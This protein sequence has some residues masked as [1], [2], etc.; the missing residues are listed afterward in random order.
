MCLLWGESILGQQK[1]S[2]SMRQK[3][4]N[5]DTVLKE[6]DSWFYDKKKN[7]I[8]KSIK[9][10]N[11][12]RI[13]AGSNKALNDTVDEKIKK[14]FKAIRKQKEEAIQ[15]EKKAKLAEAKANINAKALYWASEADKLAP[16]QAINL[17]TCAEKFKN[18]DSHT[19]VILHE[20]V[21]RIFNKNNQW[22]ERRR[23]SNAKTAWFSPNKKW[24]I[25][26]YKNKLYQVEDVEHGKSFMDCKKTSTPLKYASFSD[27][28]IYLFTQ[29]MLGKCVVW[30]MD[31][32]EQIAKTYH[33]RN[34]VQMLYLKPHQLLVCKDVDGR[35]KLLKRDTTLLSLENVL[36]M[37]FSPQRNWL[38]IK[39]MNGHI[40]LY[41]VQN[42]QPEKQ[43]PKVI[44]AIKFCSNDKYF[45][46]QDNTNLYTIYQ[47][48]NDSIVRLDSSITAISFSQDGKWVLKKRASVQ[49]KVQKDVLN[50]LG[51]TTNIEPKNEMLGE[52]YNT[53]KHWQVIENE[54]SREKKLS[55]IPPSKDT[56][57]LSQ[58]NAVVRLWDI[59]INSKESSLVKALIPP[60]SEKIKKLFSK[61]QK[62]IDVENIKIQ[63]IWNLCQ[64]KE[65]ER[66]K[67]TVR[68]ATFSPDSKWLVTLYGKYPNYTA[69]VWSAEKGVLHDFLKDEKMI[70]DAIFS[71]DS[72]W[73]VTICNDSTA[74]VWSAEKGVLHNLLK[75]EK[76]ISD[77]TF[78]PDSK[79]LVTLYG[80]YPNYTAKVWSMEKGILHDFLKEDSTIRDATF[81]PDS[82]WLI[83]TDVKQNYKVWSVEKGILH[84]FLKEDSTI[85]D[86]T[87]SPDNKWLVTIYNDG[88]AKVWSM[89][90]GI[91]HNFL[92]DEKMISDV[93]FSRDS[94][95]FITKDGNDTY[96]VWSVATGKY[97]DFLKDEKTISD[98]TFSQDSKWLI[99]KDRNDN[100]KVWSVEKGIQAEFLKQEQSISSA[101]FSPDSKWLV[102]T[103]R[104]NTAK[105]WSV[106]T[107]KYD[108]FLKDEKTISDATFSQDSKWLITKD[109][110]DN[111]KVWS[112][113]KRGQ[114]V[115]LKQER[116][117]S[118]VTFSK[119]SQYL[120][121]R[122]ED[123]HQV[124]TYEVATGKLLQTL[125]L[126]KVPK[127]IDIIDNR[128]LFVTVGKAIV[129]TDIQTQQGN[130]MSYGDG[131][132]LDYEYEEIQAWIEA[133]GDKY[134]MPLE[135]EIKK[136]YDI[137]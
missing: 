43:L 64:N 67:D 78:S 38:N 2:A 62:R 32:K 90:K 37:S 72:K 127:D 131:E 88:T 16:S 41:N 96:K 71:P 15:N 76:T 7:D 3:Q 98:A 5:F 56:L 23:F 36:E 114:A 13:L 77:A 25:I 115:F 101:T 48:Q 81:S 87:F 49:E 21:E 130:L 93:T 11:V 105:V 106:E 75:G 116:N 28:G 109:G 99:T 102:T 110:N 73:L 107:G 30:D 89:E 33:K 46:V 10:Y 52:Y 129:K 27:D 135:E 84:D 31:K 119:N 100:S 50:K 92:K 9:A 4:Y 123:N 6:G 66:L 103:Y 40:T 69:K 47:K 65:V 39:D 122:Q 58:D 22:L 113:D 59:S 108:D 1:A 91:L 94:Q 17:L 24:I 133:F 51:D 42:L 14:I 121:I 12:A 120:S 104:N 117:I 8:I 137:K 136:K 118:G 54:N 126:N 82:K 128:Y 111:Y 18:K 55:L 63:D 70:S 53:N 132:A 74:K 29:D 34:I 35:I 61:E 80:K 57:F 97:Y 124:K 83:T 60:A 134:L 79:W 85:R 45:A 44:Y 68:Y 19:Y 26:Q 86:V 112:L 20:T 95:W 125:W